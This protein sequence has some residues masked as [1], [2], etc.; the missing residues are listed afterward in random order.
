VIDITV[1]ALVLMVMAWLYAICSAIAKD[2]SEEGVWAGLAV[3]LL[4]TMI[5]GFIIM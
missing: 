3:A 4:G 1:F 5:A 2:I